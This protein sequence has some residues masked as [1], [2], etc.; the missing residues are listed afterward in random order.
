M[1]DHSEM[2]GDMPAEEFRKYGYEVVDW[3]AN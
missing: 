1:N 3:I 2:L